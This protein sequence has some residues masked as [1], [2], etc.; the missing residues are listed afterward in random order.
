[1]GLANTSKIVAL[2][3]LL[4][5][6]SSSLLAAELDEQLQF[7]QSVIGTEWIGGFVGSEVPDIEISLQF[8]IILDGKSVRYVRV[9]EAAD[10]SAVTHFYWNAGRKEVCFLSLNN[11]GIVGEGVVKSEDG[12]IVLY[13]KSHR[14]DNTTEFKTTLEIDS[15]GTLR[16]TFLRMENG[17]W[18]QGHVQEFVKKKE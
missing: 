7:L 16:D 18:V 9:A 11:R 14:P 17:K 6:L 13:G 8:E 5:S 4:V 1:M 15:K 2:L 12:R 10:F 3:F